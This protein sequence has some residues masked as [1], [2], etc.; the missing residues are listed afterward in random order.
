MSDKPW[1][2]GITPR[3]AVEVCNGTRP[4]SGDMKR[5]CWQF[6]HDSKLAYNLE[7]PYAETVRSMIA[8]GMI[9]QRKEP[10][11]WQR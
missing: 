7:G 10:P 2:Q 3:I 4:A 11:T 1:P 6:M 9:E 8:D 5:Q